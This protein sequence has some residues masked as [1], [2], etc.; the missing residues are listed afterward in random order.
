MR[1]STYLERLYYLYV[2]LCIYILLVR[3]VYTISVVQHTPRRFI[4]RHNSTNVRRNVSY[5][6]VIKILFIR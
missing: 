6:I 3:V 1:L 2:S 4:Y 5:C